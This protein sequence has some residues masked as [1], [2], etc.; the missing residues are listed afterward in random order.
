[1]IFRAFVGGVWE[2]RVRSK[3]AVVRSWFNKVAKECHSADII[4]VLLYDGERYVKPE[5]F[6]RHPRKRFTGLP[7]I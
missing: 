7:C 1:M 5:N 3:F 6:L 4:S 2:K